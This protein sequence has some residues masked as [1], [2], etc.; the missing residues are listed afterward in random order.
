MPNGSKQNVAANTHFCVACPLEALFCTI[1]VPWAYMHLILL[2][3][4]QGTITVRWN[5]GILRFGS[6]CSEELAV[7]GILLREQPKIGLWVS[8]LH[9]IFRVGKYTQSSDALSAVCGIMR[10]LAGS[11]PSWDQR[12]VARFSRCQALASVVSKGTRCLTLSNSAMV[13]SPEPE[14]VVPMSHDGIYLTLN[15]CRA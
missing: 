12:H 5:M 2:V 9:A 11:W 3:E 1:G 13:L 15:K 6:L 8:A 10:T 4:A 14:L 7:P